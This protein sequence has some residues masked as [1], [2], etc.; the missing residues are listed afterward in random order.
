LPHGHSIYAA[1]Q[2]I[3]AQSPA[4]CPM[5][6]FLLRPPGSEAG[7]ARQSGLAGWRIHRRVLATGAGVMLDEARIDAQRDLMLAIT[8]WLVNVVHRAQQAHHVASLVTP[9]T[10]VPVFVADH[11]GRVIIDHEAAIANLFEPA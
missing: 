6:E 9:R 11:L 5:A 3:A 8:R 1:R 2:V 7:A 10:W 4:V